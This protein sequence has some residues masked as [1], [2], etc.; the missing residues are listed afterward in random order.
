MIAML[1]GFL[2]L[3]SI[4]IRGG[5]GYVLESLVVALQFLKRFS[6]RKFTI[7]RKK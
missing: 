4:L 1:A 2:K 7:T 6:F 3:V 5:H